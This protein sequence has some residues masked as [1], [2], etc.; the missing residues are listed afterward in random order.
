MTGEAHTPQLM[1]TSGMGINSI[2]LLLWSPE[3]KALQFFP[4]V[5]QNAAQGD[6]GAVGLYNTAGLP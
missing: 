2:M 3:R 4:W 5:Q 6:G 1:L